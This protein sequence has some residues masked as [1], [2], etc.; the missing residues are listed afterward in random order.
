MKLQI[1]ADKKLDADAALCAAV[2]NAR[3]LSLQKRDRAM[4]PVQNNI[5]NGM[6]VVGAHMQPGSLPDAQ[7][8]SIVL[9]VE[10]LRCT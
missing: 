5:N 3:L 9:L 4:R 10:L 7:H 8:C 2:E 1:R 6:A